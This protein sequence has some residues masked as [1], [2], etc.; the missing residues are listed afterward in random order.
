VGGGVTCPRP[1]DLSAFRRG[2]VL[3]SCTAASF[4]NR[5]V[6]GSFSHCEP[7]APFTSELLVVS[8]VDTYRLPLCP[9]DAF[10]NALPVSKLCFRTDSAF[11]LQFLIG[12]SHQVLTEARHIYTTLF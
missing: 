6:R 3:R 12:A 8:D 1:R 7:V 11:S 10:T 2:S 5:D 9:N 4:L